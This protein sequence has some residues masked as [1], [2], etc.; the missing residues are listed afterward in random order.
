MKMLLA[1]LRSGSLVSTG[2][3]NEVV[4]GSFVSSPRPLKL[5]LFSNHFCCVP[6]FLNGWEKTTKKFRIFLYEDLV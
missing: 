1:P 3:R 4:V 2:E 6:L 5:H